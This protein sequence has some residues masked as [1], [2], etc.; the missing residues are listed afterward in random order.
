MGIVLVCFYR[1]DKS[2]RVSENDVRLG[3]G[4]RLRQLL[5]PPHIALGKMNIEPDIMAFRP[6]Q[7][8][9]FLP[10]RCERI[11]HLRDILR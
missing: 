8:T 10:K 3:R 6:S 2:R 5:D 7:P 11:L 1:S 4:H 9:E